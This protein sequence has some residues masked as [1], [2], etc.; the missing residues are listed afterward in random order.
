[1]KTSF[2]KVFAVVLALAM[3]LSAIPAMADVTAGSITVK[4]LAAAGDEVYFLQVIK[5]DANMNNWVFVSDDIA[6]IFVDAYKTDAK[7]PT[8]AEVIDMMITTA[9]GEGS[10]NS[11]ANAGAVSSSAE[12][13]TAIKNV[14][15]EGYAEW[16]KLTVAN[17]AT[18]VVL[19]IT[20]LTGTGVYAIKAVNND[21]S[22]TYNDMAAFVNFTY[23]NVTTAVADGI[24]TVSVEAKSVTN[25][26]EKDAQSGSESLAL[27]DEAEYVIKT[28][29]P[30]F[31]SV[32][33]NPEFILTDSSANL[34]MADVELVIKVM[35]GDTV[36]ATL[37]E[38]TDYS[39][40]AETGSFV[41][42][43][44][45]NDDTYLTYAGK[46]VVVEVSNVFVTSFA[47]DANDVATG[48]VVNKVT[49]TTDPNTEDSESAL[50]VDSVYISDTFEY[51]LT[52]TN[53]YTSSENRLVLPGAE[54]KVTL[55][56]N[57]N[58]D[59]LKFTNVSDGVYTLDPKG[60]VTTLANHS[61][62]GTL[63]LRG[64]DGDVP[65]YIYETK[66][67][68]G[69]TITNTPVTVSGQVVTESA[70]S[71]TREQVDGLNVVVTTTTT[72]ATVKVNGEVATIANMKGDMKN[73]ELG[74]LPSTGGIG[75]Y[76]FTMVGT[77]VMAAA[78]IFFMN[79][80]E[81][82]EA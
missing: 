28:T 19:N 33:Q 78:V 24:D 32:L 22:A 10:D 30:D 27:G 80:K 1:M 21:A 18:S 51:Q 38:D 73:S 5:P 14:I 31:G 39:V 13:R 12:F 74:A 62:N 76:V 8:A 36:V 4:N 52:K 72:T 64:L 67:P 69:Y 53:A 54:F 34:N 17:G 9:A 29:Y 3:V 59:A 47:T 35:N 66:A 50:R 71:T 15:A 43:F 7:T 37:V 57:V 42:T 77:A 81:S 6:A 49:V 58:A 11:T 75:T 46:Q 79:R 70:V 44:V 2:K 20:E 16:T 65:Y 55:T 63:E 40:D 25:T 23:S 41:V 60:T 82:V 45:V 56:N 68:A 26:V 61:T 48:E